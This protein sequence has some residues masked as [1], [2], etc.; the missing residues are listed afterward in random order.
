MRRPILFQPRLAGEF[1]QMPPA[2]GDVGLAGVDHQHARVK[3]QLQKMLLVVA[4][5]RSGDGHYLGGDA[6][7]A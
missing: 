6:L 7:L 3:A 4:Q 5:Y 1:G 2:Q